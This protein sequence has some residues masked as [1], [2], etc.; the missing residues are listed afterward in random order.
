MIPTLPIFSR[1][2]LT[3]DLSFRTLAD[4]CAETGSS[5]VP[6]L[7]RTTRFVEARIRWQGRP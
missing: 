5:G 1:A 4:A 3:P 7:M 2:L 6:G